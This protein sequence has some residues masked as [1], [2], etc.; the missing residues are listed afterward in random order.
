M[1]CMWPK[2]H[3]ALTIVP[4]LINPALHNHSAAPGPLFAMFCGARCAAATARR[5]ALAGRM[6]RPAALL[7]P[8]HCRAFAAADADGGA[9]GGLFGKGGRFVG[10]EPPCHFAWTALRFRTFNAM[11]E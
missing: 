3:C 4:S 6:L 5:P 2:A 9:R 8:R 1:I 10:T 11:Q 7:Q